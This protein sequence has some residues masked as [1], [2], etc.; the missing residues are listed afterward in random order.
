MVG[1]DGAR[2][3]FI[4]HKAVIANRAPKLLGT[5]ESGAQSTIALPDVEPQ[6]FS[7]YLQYLYTRRLPSKPN[8]AQPTVAEHTAEITLLCRLF[9]LSKSVGDDQAAKDA[10]N[11][12]YAEAHEVPPNNLHV[13]L[14]SSV[15]V[16]MIYKVTDRPCGTRRL[17]VDLYI[18]KAA[19]K[20]VK[21]HLGEDPAY[22]PE[23]LSDLAVALLEQRED[24]SKVARMEKKVSEY[25]D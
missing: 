15:G 4:V 12:I 19:S 17:L 13:M 16:D 22:P 24:R 2:K 3:S 25:Y 18:W 11:A 5:L 14:P 23:F 10:T 1:S 9:V 8:N 6:V 20:W 7:L 21:D